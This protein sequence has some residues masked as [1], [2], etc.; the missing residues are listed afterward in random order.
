MSLTNRVTTCCQKP[1]MRISKKEYPLDRTYYINLSADVC[2]GCMD[3]WPMTLESC[4]ICGDGADHLVDTI[5]GNVCQ[6]CCVTYADELVV[7]A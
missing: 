5:L 6:P 7:K 1:V 3:E 2:S 4:D